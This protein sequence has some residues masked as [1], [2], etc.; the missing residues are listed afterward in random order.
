ML[1]QAPAADSRIL[2]VKRNAPC[3]SKEKVYQDGVAS[4]IAQTHLPALPD[5]LG[6]NR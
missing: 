3:C 6:K 5:R 4:G 2:P 1:L